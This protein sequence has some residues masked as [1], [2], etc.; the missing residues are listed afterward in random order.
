MDRPTFT[1]LVAHDIQSGRKRQA[2]KR[3][4]EGELDANRRTDTLHRVELTLDIDGFEHLLKMLADAIGLSGMLDYVQIYWAAV[5]EESGQVDIES[6]DVV[7]SP[8][9]RRVV[10]GAV[11]GIA[12]LFHR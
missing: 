3:Y 10:G 4:L 8:G 9:M 2:F 7:G 1:Y 5:D 11:D 12:G 6:A